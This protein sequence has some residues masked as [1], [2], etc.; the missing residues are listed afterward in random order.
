MIEFVTLNTIINDLLYI[1]RGSQVSSNEPISE[2]QLENWVHQYRAMLIKRDLDK[3]KVPNPDYIQEIPMLRLVSEDRVGSLSTTF[4]SGVHIFRTELKLPKT[5][6][7]NYKSGITAVQTAVGQEIQLIPQGRANWQQYK[8]YTANMPMAYL[9]DEYLYVINTGGLEFITIRGIFE[10]P[11]EVMN[12]INLYTTPTS[13]DLNTPYPIP[14]SMVPVLKEMILKG[15][16]RIMVT[17][18][19]DQKNDAQFKV[20]PQLI[21]S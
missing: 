4:Q 6:D 21:Q 10:V 17:Q 20:E 8:T 19:S 9:K 15:E 2:R 16:L 12:F 11:T 1:I 3:G 7:F 14:I 13:G 5:L 18:P